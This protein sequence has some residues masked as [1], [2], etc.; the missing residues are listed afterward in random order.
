LRLLRTSTSP[1][2]AHHRPSNARCEGKPSTRSGPPCSYRARSLMLY[3][4][5]TNDR[6]NVHT[7]PSGKALL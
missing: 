7:C 1:Y 5:F 4:A 3:R 2:T 6:S